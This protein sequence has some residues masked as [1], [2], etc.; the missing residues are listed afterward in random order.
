VIFSLFLPKFSAISSGI[1]DE[2]GGLTSDNKLPGFHRYAEWRD[3]LFLD[4]PHDPQDEL[5][6]RCGE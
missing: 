3:R 6:E 1:R 5:F 2:G 4:E